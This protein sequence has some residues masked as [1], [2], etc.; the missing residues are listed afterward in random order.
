MHVHNGIYWFLTRR[1]WI[2]YLCKCPDAG[3]NRRRHAKAL[4]ILCRAFFR[5]FIRLS[6]SSSVINFSVFPHVM[7]K[8]K[9]APFV[10]VVLFLLLLLV[11][12]LFGRR[13]TEESV[14]GVCWICMLKIFEPVCKL[15]VYKNFWRS[16][17]GNKLFTYASS[18][19]KAFP[20]EKERFLCAK[21]KISKEQ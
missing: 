5:R 10:L 21:M 18:C 11:L 16:Y 2:I 4:S 3:I 1:R 14:D 17:F 6:V 9:I 12:G 7:D 20:F 8:G 15:A 19:S 13:E